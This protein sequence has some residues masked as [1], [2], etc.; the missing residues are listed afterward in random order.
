MTVQ[1][2]LIARIA[3]PAMLTEAYTWFTTVNL[4]LAALGSAVAGAVVD[5]PA[6]AVGGFAACALAAAVAAVVAAWPGAVAPRRDRAPAGPG[7]TLPRGNDND[8]HV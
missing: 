8:S 3:P 5:G 1:A 7:S 6:G 2:G 4:S